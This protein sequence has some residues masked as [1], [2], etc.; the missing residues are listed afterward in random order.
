[1]KFKALTNEIPD[2]EA[3]YRDAARFDRWRVGGKAFFMPGGF[4]TTAYL[5]LE[6]IRSA[7]PHDFSVK[8]GN[9]C[10]GTIITGG[11]VIRYGENEIIKIIPGSE[12]HAHRLM[13]ALKERLPDLDTEIPEIYRGSTRKL[14]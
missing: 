7:Y 6:E 14:I 3:D 13:E 9:C 1:M 2:I 8:G 11:V 5:P 10:T 12:R 4:N